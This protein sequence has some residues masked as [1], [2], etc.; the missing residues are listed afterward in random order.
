M[1]SVPKPLKFLRPQY[2]G[3][4]LK[5]EALPAGAAHRAALADVV[6]V[7]AMTS[8]E[9]GSRQCLKYKLQASGVLGGDGASVQ[10]VCAASA[11]CCF[12]CAADA[13][14][15]P[16]VPTAAGGAGERRPLGARVHSPPVG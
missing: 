11:Q 3:L 9:E 8:A 6:S 14:P 1:T 7:L 5:L 12:V 10:A 13:Q 16:P 2:E 15:A 4:R